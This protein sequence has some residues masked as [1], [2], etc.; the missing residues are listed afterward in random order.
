[1]GSKARLLLVAL[2]MGV[3]YQIVQ[4]PAVR[5]LYSAEDKWAHAA[6]FFAVWWALR[7][8]TSWRPATIAVVSA[9]LG[10]AVEV[11]QIF[12]P[13][14]NPSWADWAA[15][16]AGILVACMLFAVIPRPVS[17]ASD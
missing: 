14:F 10:A 5:A 9:G 15:N 3:G 4:W 7:W 8:A 11:H 1:M 17:V 2:C 6:A 16:G 13:G 12:L